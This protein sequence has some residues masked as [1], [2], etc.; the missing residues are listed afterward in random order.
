MNSR[1][2]NH[3]NLQAR[4]EALKKEVYDIRKDVREFFDL[5]EKYLAKEPSVEPSDQE[6]ME[7][8]VLLHRV[9]ANLKLGE[10][11]V[12]KHEEVSGDVV[13]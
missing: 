6:I 10:L 7:F 1:A 3:K 12:Q 11:N 8:T 4:Y 9:R 5:F 2:R 13:V